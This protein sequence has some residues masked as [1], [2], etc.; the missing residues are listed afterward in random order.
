MTNAYH[1][2]IKDF[3][4][5]EMEL[6]D[7]YYSYIILKDK[8]VKIS[9]IPFVKAFYQT[10]KLYYNPKEWQRLKKDLPHLDLLESFITKFI[11]SSIGYIDSVP[12][13]EQKF[14]K[15]LCSLMLFEEKRIKSGFYKNV[16]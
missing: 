11:A 3:C 12:K 4:S 10:A 9:N 16:A 5:V 7:T 14:V 2:L 6:I 1:K 15:F 13:E 8:K